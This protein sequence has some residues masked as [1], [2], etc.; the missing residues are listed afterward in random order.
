MVAQSF[1]WVQQ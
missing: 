1:M